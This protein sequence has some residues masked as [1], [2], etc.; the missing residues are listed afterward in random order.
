MVQRDYLMLD[1]FTDVP[2]GGSR[3]ALFTDGHGLSTGMMQTIA[4]EM[5]TCETAFVI[6]D[7]AAPLRSSLRTGCTAMHRARFIAPL[8][9]ARCRRSRA[10]LPDC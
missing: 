4:R 3:L 1:V 9:T 8:P 10:P 7:E 2:F 5:G 6:P